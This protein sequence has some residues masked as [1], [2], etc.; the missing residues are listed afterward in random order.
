LRRDPGNDALVEAVV[1]RLRALPPSDQV[2]VLHG[3]LIPA[4]VLVQQGHVTGVLDFGFLTTV[5]DPHFD[6]AITA[7]IFD[8]YGPN[9]RF[10]E[11]LLD[12]HFLSRFGHDPHRYALYRA[13]YAIV[14]HA[15]FGSDGT[16]GHFR[17]CAQML[18]RSD[19]RDSVLR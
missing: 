18:R 17:W 9:A 5:G 10:S 2:A 15:Y 6:A 7:S 13:A 16:D 19:V 3:D 8:M 11:D 1:A 12:Q 4:N 14:T